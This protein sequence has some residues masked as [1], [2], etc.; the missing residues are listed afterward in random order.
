[1][2]HLNAPRGSAAA[3]SMLRLPVSRAAPAT[4]EAVDLPWR[5]LTFG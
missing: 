2:T 5:N 4:A 3:E 1:M